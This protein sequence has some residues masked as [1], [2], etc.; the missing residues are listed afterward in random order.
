MNVLKRSL[1]N[2]IKTIWSFRPSARWSN[3]NSLARFPMLFFEFIHLKLNFKIL[4]TK[5]DIAT[6]IRFFLIFEIFYNL[7]SGGPLWWSIVQ[8]KTTFPQTVSMHYL[9]AGIR[10]ESIPDQH[11]QRLFKWLHFAK[12]FSLL[13]SYKVLSTGKMT[14]YIS[15]WILKKFN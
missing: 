15:F 1:Y 8:Y 3:K 9:P 7:F 12:F 4:F 14:S 5:L 2:Q 10:S 13:I 6:K 11:L